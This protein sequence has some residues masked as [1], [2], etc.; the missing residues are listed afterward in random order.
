[1]RSTRLRRRARRAGATRTFLVDVTLLDSRGVTVET[2]ASRRGRAGRC[3]SRGCPGSTACCA[4]ATACSSGCCASRGVRSCCG[5][6]SRPRDRVVLDAARR[7]P[8]RRRVGA[9]ALALRAGRRRRPARLPRALPLRSADRALGAPRPP[10]AARAPARALR[11]A[12]LGGVRAA[13]RHRERR[14]RSSAGSCAAGAVAAPRRGCATRPPPPRWPRAAP[15]EL[16]ACGL[17]AS[18]AIALRRAAREVAAG[19]ADLH[20]PDHERAWARLRAHPR[21][22]LV[23]GRDARPARAGPPRPGARRRPGPAQARRPPAHRQSRARVHEDEV[24][25]FFAPYAPWGGLAARHALHRVA[26]RAGADLGDVA[27]RAHARRLGP[28][29]RWPAGPRRAAWTEALDALLRRWT[30]TERLVLLGDVVELAEGRPRR[31]HGGRRSRSCGGSARGSAAAARSSSCPATTT[32][33]SCAR[34][35]ARARDAARRSTR[36]S[37]TT[38][39]RC[40]PAWRHGWPRPPC[41]SAT[42]ASGCRGGCGRRTATTWTATCSRRPPTASRAG[43]WAACRA[44]TP[45]P[46]T[47]NAPAGRRSRAW[48]RSPPAGSPAR[49]PSWPDDLAELL[50]AATMPGIPRRLVSRRT[51]PPRPRGCSGRRCAARAC[52]RSRASSTGSRS[53]PTGSC[54]ATSTAPARS[55]ATTSR[56]WSGPVGRPRIVN[57]GSWVY[58]P[59]L[60][61]HA[62]PPHPYW[63]GGAVLLEDGDGPRVVGLLD[64]L[65]ASR[66]R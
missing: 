18:R 56:R 61:H 43:R 5:R 62:T 35:S 11:G 20:A 51:S 17:S 6:P 10:P 12:G 48:R 32:P 22:R 46:A 41:A 38:P 21:D 55:R 23:D 29:P 37:R 2:T 65:D 3:A 34:G 63:P 58:E 42:P 64:H 60:V 33:T 39:R 36:R 8:R 50:R 59:L 1:M 13:H 54:S 53:T 49:W 24:R 14:G 25:E 52:R 26:R 19:R 15:A 44:T 27:A 57:C 16:E 28:P 66:L 30:G 47:T 4:A 31:G 7:G 45:R 9:R 40:S